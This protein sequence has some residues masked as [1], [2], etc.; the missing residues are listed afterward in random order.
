MRE[1]LRSRSH[2]QERNA[3]SP[4]RRSVP[5]WSVLDENHAEKTHRTQSKLSLVLNKND[6]FFRKWWL[7]SKPVA[8][9]DT[10]AHWLISFN[11]FEKKRKTNTIL[12]NKHTI[13]PLTFRRHLLVYNAVTLKLK[14]KTQHAHES[15][16]WKHCQ[17]TCWKVTVVPSFK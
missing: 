16:I 7:T 8:D 2:S 10:F 3:G 15:T 6:N 17:C 9:R 11:W 13:I 4:T 1:I 5:K 12:S 14:K